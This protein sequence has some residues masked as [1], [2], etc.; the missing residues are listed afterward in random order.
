M[1][2]F[3]S[4]GACSLAP[5]I[6]LLETGAKFTLEKVDLKTKQ[7]SGGDFKKINP[8][9]AVPTIQLDNGEV[10]TEGA[11]VLQYLADLKPEAELMPKAGTWERYKTQEWLNF[12][13]SDIHK[14]FGVLFAASRWVA[15]A[16]GND[17]LKSSAREALSAKLNLVA[18]RLEKNDFLM[19]KT[20]T[21]PDAY[22]FTCLRWSAA[23]SVDL[24]KWPSITKFMERVAA[25]PKVQ[26]AMKSEGLN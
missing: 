15:N 19:G 21:A 4:P 2:L 1:T 5:H 20:F 9:G 12:V 14:G 8:K 11:V 17:Q 13:A 23:M 6:V 7:Y 3:Y 16:E 18:E 10:L 22:L 24:K 26:A 25:R